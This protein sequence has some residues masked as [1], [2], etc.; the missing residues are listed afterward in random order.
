M[1]ISNDFDMEN[2]TAGQIADA[3]G[4]SREYTNAFTAIE[5]LMV[6]ADHTDRHGLQFVGRDELSSLIRVVNSGLRRHIQEIETAVQKLQSSGNA[7]GK[8][9]K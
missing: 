7:P 9:R 2:M 1:L 8:V 5:E 6:P 4:H 3:I